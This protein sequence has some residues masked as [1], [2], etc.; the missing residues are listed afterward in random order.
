MT[1]LDSTHDAEREAGWL[2]HYEKLEEL[3]DESDG[4]SDGNEAG[5]S[6]DLAE[7]V[8]PETLFGRGQFPAWREGKRTQLIENTI[9]IGIQSSIIILNFFNKKGLAILYNNVK[10]FY[11]S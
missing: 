9:S 5:K 10:K 6:G 7:V 8:E 11:I 4:A 2:E 1:H 3:H